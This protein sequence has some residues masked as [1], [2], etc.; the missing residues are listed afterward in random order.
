MSDLEAA[1]LPGGG[2]PLDVHGGYA[3]GGLGGPVPVD[4]LFDQG[5]VSLKHRLDAAVRPIAD[6][7]LEAEGPGLLRAVRTE[8]DSLDPPMEVNRRADQHEAIERSAT[9]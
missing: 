1:E 4:A 2:S 5:P 7:A 9:K 6:V 3:G 8:V